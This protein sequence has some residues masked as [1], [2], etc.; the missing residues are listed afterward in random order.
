MRRSACPCGALRA[1]GRVVCASCWRTAPVTARTG[2]RFTHS[3]EDRRVAM[4]ALLTH[5]RSRAQHQ[6]P[7]T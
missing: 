1:G 3:I 6:L 7:L 2:L 4:R 5:A